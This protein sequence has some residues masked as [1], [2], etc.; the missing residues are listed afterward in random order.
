MIIIKTNMEKTPTS[1]KECDL[2]VVAPKMI[3]CPVLHDW[4]EP[5]E[6]KNGKVKLENCPLEEQKNETN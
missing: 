1:C 6:F 4:I 3:M 2:R 5:F